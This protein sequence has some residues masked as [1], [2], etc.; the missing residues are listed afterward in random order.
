MYKL[1]RKKAISEIREYIQDEILPDY[2]SISETDKL[3]GSPMLGDMI[4]RNPANHEDQWLIAKKYFEDNFELI[5][6]ENE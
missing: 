6:S 3:N 5:T 1:Y 2:V 4:A